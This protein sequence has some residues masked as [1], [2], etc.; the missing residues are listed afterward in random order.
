MSYFSL[1]GLKA[2]AFVSCS[3]VSSV[4]NFASVPSLIWLI[5]TATSLLPMPRKPPTEST[6][7]LNA[8]WS[9]S[10]NTSSIVPMDVS[11]W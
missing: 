5:G 10:T 9:R 3:L 6:N 8:P 2:G 7:A 1:L 4:V 11:P